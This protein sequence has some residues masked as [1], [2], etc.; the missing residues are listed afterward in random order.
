MVFGW[1]GREWGE[2]AEILP[3][4]IRRRVIKGA[5]GT[6]KVFFTFRRVRQWSGIINGQKCLYVTDR[7]QFFVAIPR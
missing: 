6:G 2:E 3:L 7:A 1:P 5:R 4:L